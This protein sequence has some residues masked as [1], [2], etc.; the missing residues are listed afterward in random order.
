MSKD[1][2]SASTTS[3]TGYG[4]ADEGGTKGATKA[5]PVAS[6]VEAPIDYSS[7]LPDTGDT[8]NLYPTSPAAHEAEADRLEA[9]ADQLEAEA[10]DAR[11]AAKDARKLANEA[12]DTK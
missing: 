9:E 10:T 8:G 7:V 12:G 6:V 2:T 11:A 3:T 5:D 4:K 1:S